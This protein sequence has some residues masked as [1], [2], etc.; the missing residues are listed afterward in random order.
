[1]ITKIS[2]MMVVIMLIVNLSAHVDME[3]M[4][5]TNNENKRNVEG[6]VVLGNEILLQ[7]DTHLVE[8]RQVG[9]VTNHTGTDSEKE[10][11]ADKYMKDENVDLTALYTPEHGLD[12]KASAGE[13]VESYTHEEY[14]IPVYSLYGETRKPTD[15]ML[16]DIDILLFDM[17]DIG[18]RTYTYM[19]T[20]NYT[21][22]A[23]SDYNVPVAVLDRPNPLGGMTVAGP[24][25]E[26][27]FKSFVGVDKL[28]KA[29]GMTAGELAKYF[30]RDINADLTVVPMKGYQRNMIFQD[31]GLPWI[32]TSPNIPDLDAAFGY[33][34]TGLGE[35]TD[36]YQADKFTW[37]G[38]EGIDSEQ[39]ADRLNES[40]LEG[41]QFITED[42]NDGNH[43]GVRLNIVD[44]Y[45]FNPAKSG[46]YALAC[47]FQIGDFDVPT[48]NGNN[49]EMFDL[50]MGSDK[51]GEWLK[52]GYSPEEIEER[53][54]PELNEFKRE[55]E[56]YLLDEYDPEILVQMNNYILDFDVSPYMDENSRLQVPVRTIAEKLGGY[57]D[58]DGSNQVA[59]I[60]S[61]EQHI[62]FTIDDSVAVVNDE[63]REM[64]THARIIDG[65]TMIP[66]RYVSEFFGANVEWKGDWQRVHIDS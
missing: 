62:K 42:R 27:D 49:T 37:I 5:Q 10:K 12:G 13:Y 39:F 14:D 61:E 59:E 4:E 48:S 45:D 18:A 11:I 2:L 26:E 51:I 35:G 55:R 65:R 60:R 34:S 23:A 47:G 25:L 3:A 36:I 53:Y 38:G 29:H 30:N 8:G 28:P 32:G 31:T 19:S 21:M 54:T 7:A 46:I 58:W 9:L 63:I 41:V 64:D 16:S 20:L 15:D 17:Q 33:M 66:V 52:E 57:V 44:Y 22:E 50:I 40:D 43:G 1:M 24:M 56:Q 6:S